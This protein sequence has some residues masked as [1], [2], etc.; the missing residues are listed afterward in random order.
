MP[1]N[2]EA[3]KIIKKELDEKKVSLVAV[4]KTKSV[5]EIMELYHLGQRD[6]GENY[7]QELVSKAAQLPKISAGILSGISSVIKSSLSLLLYT[8]FTEWI[9]MICFSELQLRPAPMEE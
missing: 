2:Q 3:Y 5:E 9:V 7:V 6:F 4:S 1:V 8:L